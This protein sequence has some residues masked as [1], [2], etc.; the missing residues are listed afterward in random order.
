MKRYF[1]FFLSLTWS[2]FLQSQQLT[3]YFETTY[4]TSTTATVMVYVQRAEAG[5]ENLTGYTVDFYYDNT[6]STLT[7]FDLSPTVAMGWTPFSDKLT[8][9][10]HNNVTVPIIH[11]GFGTINVFDDN[12]IGTNIGT[13]PVH[14]ITLNFDNS[15][16]TTAASS[17][18]LASTVNRPA[19]VYINSFG[20]EFPVVVT[21][22]QSQALPLE[23]VAFTVRPL[24]GTDAQLDWITASEMNSS[25]FDIQRSVEG[26]SW[27][28]I[29]TLAAVG[30]SQSNQLYNLT[31]KKVFDPN[32]ITNPN[33]YYRLKMVDIDG[34]FE[35]SDVRQ[36]KFE[37]GDGPIVGNLF[38]NP[39]WLG[40]ASVQLQ[41]SIKGETRLQ[42]DIYDFK[43]NM[44]STNTSP[45]SIGI[46]E[47]TI[48]T[49][50]LSFGVYLIKLT[51]EDGEFFVRKL[52]VQ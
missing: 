44:V 21:G 45:L 49:G 34:H 1:I 41:I 31:D 28:T 50:S 10:A 16:G 22:Q 17:G 8:F 40:N 9:F 15:T 6:E 46:N 39:T 2:T 18:F 12:F 43:G 23:L 20:D 24:Y 38:P 52:T 42:I 19:L 5:T 13:T 35:Y 11:T 26:I 33:F 47:V 3:F 4:P 32:E 14:L 48:G 7:S 27:I 25:H 29:E 37:S 36:V 51:M 30:N